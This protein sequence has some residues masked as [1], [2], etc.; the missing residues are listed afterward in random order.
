MSP[1]VCNYSGRPR[2]AWWP[3]L[4]QG[5]LILGDLEVSNTLEVELLGCV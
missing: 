3:K 2:E 1:A 5:E 4:V